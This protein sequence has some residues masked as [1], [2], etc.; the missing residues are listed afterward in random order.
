M[1]QNI[2]TVIKALAPQDLE[3]QT[4]AFTFQMIDLNRS[5][6]IRIQMALNIIS[7][8]WVQNYGT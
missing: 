1:I 2:T 5:N 3:S 7:S 6:F 4:D 8:L